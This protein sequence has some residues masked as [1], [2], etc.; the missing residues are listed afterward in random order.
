MNDTLKR[1]HEL[2]NI[3]LDG[4]AAE[5]RI[6]E[7][8]EVAFAASVP[9]IAHPHILDEKKVLEYIEEHMF[10][11]PKLMGCSIIAN[12]INLCYRESIQQWF[13]IDVVDITQLIANAIKEKKDGR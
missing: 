5:L 1:I 12:G 4:L 6:K 9:A 8:I 3:D 11:D 2:S 10:Y 13:R 7:I